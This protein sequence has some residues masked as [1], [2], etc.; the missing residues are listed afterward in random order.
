MRLYRTHWSHAFCGTDDV[1]LLAHILPSIN[2]YL[3]AP[4][5]LGLLSIAPRKTRETLE[6]L[7]VTLQVIQ[8]V[9]VRIRLIVIAVGPYGMLNGLLTSLLGIPLDRGGE[10]VHR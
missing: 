2:L 8:D 4:Q 1:A 3:D 6:A 7:N 5:D 10:C 9:L